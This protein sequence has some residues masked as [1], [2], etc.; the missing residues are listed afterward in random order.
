MNQPEFEKLSWL[1]GRM[2]YDFRYSNIFDD[3]RRSVWSVQIVNGY[4]DKVILGLCQ[5]L[6]WSC[7]Q[8]GQDLLVK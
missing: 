7:A 5:K 2:K 8:E 1:L 4:D 3:E 6:G